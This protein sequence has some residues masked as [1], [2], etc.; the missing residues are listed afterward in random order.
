MAWQSLKE[1]DLGRGELLGIFTSSPK[2]QSNYPAGVSESEEY[3]IYRDGKN[4]FAVYQ[5]SNDPDGRSDNR[6]VRG[7]DKLDESMLKEILLKSFDFEENNIRFE[8]YIGDHSTTIKNSE[9]LGKQVGSITKTKSNEQNE[10]LT[11]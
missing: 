3:H 5:A 7:L 4:T 9:D 11:R 2:D 8:R 1:Q 6:A 10:G